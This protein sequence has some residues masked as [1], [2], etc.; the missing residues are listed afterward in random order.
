MFSDSDY[1][2]KSF[3]LTDLQWMPLILEAED[4]VLDDGA[5]ECLLHK[6]SVMLKSHTEYVQMSSF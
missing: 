1:E 3:C 4:W 6:T 5:T 2:S